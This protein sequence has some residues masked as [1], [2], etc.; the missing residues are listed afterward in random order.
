[1][2]RKYFTLGGVFFLVNKLFWYMCDI[3]ENQQMW[4]CCEYGFVCVCTCMCVFVHMYVCVPPF[5]KRK[6]VE[7][8]ST[9]CLIKMIAWVPKKLASVDK[10]GFLIFA[11][12][13]SR[14]QRKSFWKQKLTDFTQN[15]CFRNFFNMLCTKM[16]QFSLCQFILAFCSKIHFCYLNFKNRFL[17]APSFLN[18]F[19]I[20]TLKIIYYYCSTLMYYQ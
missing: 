3:V 2:K 14:S 20:T 19:D 13:C 8:I 11:E 9:L 18:F 7:A 15:Y 4:N 16:E 6:R 1:M 12:Y 5:N 10:G 17:K